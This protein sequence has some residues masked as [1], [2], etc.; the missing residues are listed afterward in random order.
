MPPPI[1][2]SGAAAWYSTGSQSGSASSAANRGLI[3]SAAAAGA[4]ASAI[5]ACTSATNARTTGVLRTNSPAISHQG[6]TDR[7]TARG[8]DQPEASEVRDV[9]ALDLARP[10]VL[11][12]VVERMLRVR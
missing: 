1:P 10:R 9:L 3:A 4:G 11:F 12:E 6:L 8:D 5:A 2:P 7:L